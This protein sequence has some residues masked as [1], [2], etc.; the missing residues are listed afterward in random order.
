MSGPA[1]T[2][3]GGKYRATGEKG[4]PEL[5][6]IIFLYQKTLEIQRFLKY[7]FEFCDYLLK[8]QWN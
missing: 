8:L 6:A 1:M 4:V 5:S 3:P 2:D 7:F